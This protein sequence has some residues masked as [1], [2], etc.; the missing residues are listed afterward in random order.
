MHT[1]QISNLYNHQKHISSPITSWAAWWPHAP[2]KQMRSPIK[3]PEVEDV[4]FVN[5]CVNWAFVGCSGR[6]GASLGGLVPTD[7]ALK[8]SHFLKSFLYF[9]TSFPHSF[10]SSPHF[11]HHHPHPISNL[12]LSCCCSSR[13][14]SHFSSS[15]PSTAPMTSSPS[16]ARCFFVIIVL[17]P[18]SPKWRSLFLP[19]PPRARWSSSLCSAELRIHSFLNTQLTVGVSIGRVIGSEIGMEIGTEIGVEIGVEIGCWRSNVGDRML[20]IASWTS[21]AIRRTVWWSCCCSSRVPW[22]N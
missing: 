9:S 17:S 20:E 2:W 10:P 12:S 19:F 6:S 7:A 8:T 22:C 21:D 3:C 4:H 16:H 15:I 5:P 18:L 13:A 1:H 14:R 11:P